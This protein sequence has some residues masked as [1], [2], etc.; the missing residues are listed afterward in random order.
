MPAQSSVNLKAH[1][2]PPHVSLDFD[3]SSPF[4]ICSTVVCLCK[5]PMF[6]NSF[7]QMEHFNF[8]RLLL[9]DESELVEVIFFTPFDYIANKNLS[10]VIH[11]SYMDD[12]TTIL[13]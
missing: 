4:C 9:L 3:G 13:P 8:G 5:S 11:K 12:I 2:L 7:P 10:R 6:S 1:L